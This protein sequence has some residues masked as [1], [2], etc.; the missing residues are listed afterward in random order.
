MF[1]LQ[2]EIMGEIKKY[3]LVLLI[4]FLFVSS[5]AYA[6]SAYSKFKIHSYNHKRYRSNLQIEPRIYYGFMISNH[7]ELQPFNAHVP[8]F[9]LSIIKDTYG[10]Q[11]WEREHNYPIIGLSFF[12]SSLSNN[13]AVGQVFALYP[14]ITFPIV[15][16]TNHFLGFKLGLG[17]SY[18]TK[19]FDPLENYKNIAIG[20]HVNVAINLMVE[21]RLK[22]NESTELTTGLS[23]IHFSNGSMATPNYGVNM[24]MLSL[25]ASK[26]LGKANKKMNSRRPQIPVFSYKANKI[27]IFNIDGGYASKNMGNVFGERFDVYTGSFSALKYFN[28]IS[29]FGLSIDF[30]WDGSHKALLMKEGIQDPSFITV[31]RPGFAP[32][33][34]MKIDRLILGVGLGFYWGGKE[35][36]DGNVYEQLTVKYIIYDNIFAKINLRAHAAR[37]AFVSFGLGYRLQYDFGIKNGK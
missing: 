9:E 22:L 5:T 32:T 11:I 8:A 12:Y 2:T 31:V 33:Y 13:P 30:S 14:F 37:A 7:T 36:S 20:S 21:Y 35:K 15:R 29:A 19:T 6:Q 26:R 28:R 24:P 10:K 23:L 17:L 25:G 4:G 3:I 16:H 18:L 27:F 1:S 34:E